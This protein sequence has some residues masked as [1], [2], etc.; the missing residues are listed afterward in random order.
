MELKLRRTAA[1]VQQRDV[2][3]R[4]GLTRATLSRYE[5]MELVPADRAQAYLQAVD[6]LGRR[7][8]GH[9]EGRMTTLEG[10]LW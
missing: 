6:E 2:A 3:R 1:R 9:G 7:S 5:G 4:M 10:R 8:H